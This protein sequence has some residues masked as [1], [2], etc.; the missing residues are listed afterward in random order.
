MR[1]NTQHNNAQAAQEILAS[2]TSW[3]INFFGNSNLWLLSLVRMIIYST[4]TSTIHKKP[5][6][7]RNG[8]KAAIGLSATNA[9]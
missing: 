3:E 9:K 7:G 6:L 8:P 2:S 5:I 1:R 4:S